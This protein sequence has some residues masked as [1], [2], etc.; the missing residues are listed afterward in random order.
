MA[1]K[2]DKLDGRRRRSVRT[3]ARLVDALIELIRGGNFTPTA[4]E[5]ADSTD[6]SIRTVFRQIEDMEGLYQSLAVRLEADVLPILNAPYETSSADERMVEFRNRRAEVFEIIMPFRIAAE[7]RALGSEQLTQ[8]HK[9]LLRRE[10]KY[11]DEAL[12]VSALENKECYDALLAIHSFAFWK[13]LRVEQEL[14]ASTAKKTI[15]FT[16]EL[17]LTQVDSS[18][19]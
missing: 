13:R 2:I 8:T 7:A 14:S 4:Q 5:I 10:R 18:A 17:L 12:P 3:R 6:L 9:G 1:T 19:D 11:L 16:S 15:D